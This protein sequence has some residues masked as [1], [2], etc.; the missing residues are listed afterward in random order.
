MPRQQNRSE[1]EVAAVGSHGAAESTKAIETVDE[2]RFYIHMAC[3][4][5]PWLRWPNF[6]LSPTTKRK[7]DSASRR[8]RSCHSS[9]RKK[10]LQLSR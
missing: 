5:K 3:P 1:V 10:K 7:L 2:I 6:R 4:R 8:S 9:R